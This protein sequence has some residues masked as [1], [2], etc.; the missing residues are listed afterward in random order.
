MAEANGIWT[1]RELRTGA[2]VLTADGARL[3]RVRGLLGRAMRVGGRL[4]W[5]WYT[6]DCIESAT[7]RE[8]RLRVRSGDLAPCRRA[9][10]DEH[11]EAE[12]W[13]RAGRSAPAHEG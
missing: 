13:L 9:G 2:L 5:R 6:T 3:G 12:R 8:V 4:R 1:A 10:P 11:A 7:P